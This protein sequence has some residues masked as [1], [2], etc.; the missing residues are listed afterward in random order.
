MGG[1]QR[2]LPFVQG[3]RFLVENLLWLVI[4]S[5]ANGLLFVQRSSCGLRSSVHLR[6]GVHERDVRLAMGVATSID[7]PKRSSR[8]R[9]SQQENA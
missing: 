5:V 3:D 2:V 7:G 6:V 4:V 9:T 8:P 1:A